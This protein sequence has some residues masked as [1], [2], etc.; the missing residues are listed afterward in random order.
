MIRA[1]VIKGYVTASAKGPRHRLIEP[2]RA[3]GI[4]PED[5]DCE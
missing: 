5:F 2:L 4:N 3:E 1:I